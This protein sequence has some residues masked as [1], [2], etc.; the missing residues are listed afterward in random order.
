MA[1]VDETLDSIIE[2]AREVRGAYHRLHAT[3]DELI[4]THPL[5][6]ID[7]LLYDL[8]DMMAEDVDLADFEADRY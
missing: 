2:Q 3:S 1:T 4:S 8:L 6:Q 5:R 7:S